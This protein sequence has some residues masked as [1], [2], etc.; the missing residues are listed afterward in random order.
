MDEKRLSLEKELQLAEEYV[1]SMDYPQEN[2]ER[3]LANAEEVAA[4]EGK[5]I[6]SEVSRIRRIWESNGAVDRMFVELRTLA[7][8]RDLDIE[9]EI[10]GLKEKFFEWK[11]SE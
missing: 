7:K 8:E 9:K 4:K 3:C 2:V 6:S 5:D 1:I 11:F 10:R